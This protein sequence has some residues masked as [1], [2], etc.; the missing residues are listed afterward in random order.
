M[1]KVIDGQ[2]WYCCTDCGKKLF[3]LAGIKAQARGIAVFCRKCKREIV[4]EI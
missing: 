4:V 1:I 3:R 2:K